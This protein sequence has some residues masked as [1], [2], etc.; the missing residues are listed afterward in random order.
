MPTLEQ[1]L[2]LFVMMTVAQVPLLIAAVINWIKS[3]ENS[4]KLDRVEEQIEE[5]HIATNSLTDRLVASTD[6]EAFAR[7]EKAGK[8][9]E[10]KESGY[11]G[12]VHGTESPPR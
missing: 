7:G 5:V 1:A 10:E 9:A 8:S 12:D 3:K 4:E 11:C 2:V 6:K